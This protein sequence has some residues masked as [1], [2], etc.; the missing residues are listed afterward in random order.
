[1]YN[2]GF[3]R[4]SNTSCLRII[5]NHHFYSTTTS[6]IFMTNLSCVPNTPSIWRSQASGPC[7]DC[8]DVVSAPLVKLTQVKGCVADGLIL[9]PK[10]LLKVIVCILRLLYSLQSKYILLSCKWLSSFASKRFFS[11]LRTT[12]LCE[13]TKTKG[14]KIKGWKHISFAWKC[15]R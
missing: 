3:T 12:Q 4:G 6:D 7:S 14:L 5:T 10:L 8:T 1:M 11:P 13:K 2:H 9:A 15:I